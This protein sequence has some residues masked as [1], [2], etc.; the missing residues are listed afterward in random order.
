MYLCDNN[1]LKTSQTKA[2]PSRI[3]KLPLPIVHYWLSLWW[4]IF[5]RGPIAPV[6]WCKCNS[7][8]AMVLGCLVLRHVALPRKPHIPS[9]KEMSE[10]SLIHA[11]LSKSNWSTRSKISI[12]ASAT[13]RSCYPLAAHLYRTIWLNFQSIYDHEH[14]SH[15]AL[16]IPS[17]SSITLLHLS[18]QLSRT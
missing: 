5:T 16:S 13:S 17:S 18:F 6:L 3:Q 8:I 10:C 9:L 2:D 7:A 4:S 11:H 12:V 1:A 15:L 14:A